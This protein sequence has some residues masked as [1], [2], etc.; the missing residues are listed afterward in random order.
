MAGDGH[1]SGFFIDGKGHLLTNQHVVRTA[2][3]AKIRFADGSELV[4][5][6]IATDERRDVALLLAEEAK[7]TGLPI[8]T[9]EMKVG[10]TVYAM[11]SPLDQEFQSTLTRG[12]VSALRTQDG[13]P[14]IQSD[15]NV[16]P[17]NSGGPLMDESGNVV[18]ISDLAILDSSG[19][20]AGLNLFIP[21]GT[22]L[23]KMN[24]TLAAQN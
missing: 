23:T 12:V 24:V 7:A 13:Y 22:G 3:K 21:I 10:E 18:G 9:R 1:G 2:E 4:A 5:K 8:R 6:V 11:G 19:V 15:V 14:F 16:R 20:E 17:G